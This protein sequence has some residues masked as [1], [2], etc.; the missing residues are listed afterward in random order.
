M[1]R[2]AL[3]TFCVLAMFQ[4]EI[5]RAEYGCQSGFV[6]VYQGNRQVCVA[7]YNL[8]VWQQKG[9]QQQQPGEIWEDR[10]GVVSWSDEKGYLT[11]VGMSTK[12]EAENKAL[13]QC[14][15]NCKIVGTFRNSC[16]AI[17]WGSGKALIRG[18]GSQ[19]EAEENSISE[20]RKNGSTCEILSSACSLPVR[21]Q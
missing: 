11:I 3:F 9:Q 21:I 6:P 18:G 14:G 17:S 4:G 10:Y 2:F 19:Q 20:C 7:D 8:P 15:S 1:K 16:T 12:K 5:A 13:S